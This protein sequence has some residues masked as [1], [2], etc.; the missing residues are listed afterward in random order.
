MRF[1]ELR[2]VPRLEPGNEEKAPQEG[3]I[4]LY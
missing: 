1:P 2:L 4:H 3:E